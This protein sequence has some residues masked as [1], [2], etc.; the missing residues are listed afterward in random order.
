MGFLK[1]DFVIAVVFFVVSLIINLYRVEE[2]PPGMY[3]DEVTLGRK[4]V[5]LWESKTLT[6]FLGDYGHPTPLLYLAGASIELFGR[7]PTAIRLPIIIIGALNTVLFYFLLRLFL[8]KLKSVLGAAIWATSYT[9]IVLNR[10]A[11]EPPASTFCQLAFLLFVFLFLKTKKSYHLIFAGAALGAGLYTYLNFR[12]FFLAAI[13]ATYLLLKN[14]K[15][16]FIVFITTIIILLPLGVFA[17]QNPEP[18]FS[19]SADISVF[20]RKLPREE[21]IKEIAGSTWRTLTM[22]GITGDPNPGKN[23]AGVPVF[24][25]LTS[26]LF[27]AGAVII[28]K[29]KRQFFW[30]ILMFC[31]AALFSDIFSIEQIPEFHYY[32]LGHPNALRVSGF[33]IPVIFFATIAVSKFEYKLAIIITAVICLLNLFWYFNQQ[34]LNPHWYRYNWQINKQTLLNMI[35]YINDIKY[36]NIS[37]DE[38]EQRHFFLSKNVKVTTASAVSAYLINEDNIEKIKNIITPQ[39]VIFRNPAGFVEGVIIKQ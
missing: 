25:P 10:L 14:F 24:D 20:G 8:D 12:L 30:S 39:S 13:P 28:F 16:T 32:G 31:L 4:A 22:F 35:G 26:I 15:L 9:S 6:P 33:L 7:T 36:E 18:F 34:N 2:I 17:I 11:Y 29:T 5:A 27:L 19:R 3:G 21:V 23:P 1:K 38:S 37:M